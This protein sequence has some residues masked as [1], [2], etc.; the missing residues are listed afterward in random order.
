MLRAG[1]QFF[2]EPFGWVMLALFGVCVLAVISIF[3]TI[4]YRLDMTSLREQT[5]AI[6]LMQVTL[7]MLIG[8]TS[9]FLGVLL[10]W[11]GIAESI[12]AEMSTG[13]TKAKL[14]AASPGAPRALVGTGL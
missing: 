5:F 7:G 2:T 3:I 10:S 14:A 12:E 13:S 6:R 9:A 11:F 4:W 8:L 1:K